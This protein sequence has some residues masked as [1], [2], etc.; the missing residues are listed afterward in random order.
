MH[1]M[2]KNE[3]EKEGGH[4]N[5]IEERVTTASV[6]G[7]VASVRLEYNITWADESNSVLKS[8]QHLACRLPREISRGAHSLKNTL[9]E[10]P[11]RTP[12]IMHCC[13]S[14]RESRGQND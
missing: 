13:V 4:V 8:F 9:D 10:Q 12:V 7:K 5:Q 1:I 14:E 2:W 6:P 11:R 3:A